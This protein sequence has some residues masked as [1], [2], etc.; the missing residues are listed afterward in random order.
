MSSS[1]D[2]VNEMTDRLKKI[3]SSVGGGGGEDPDEA[4]QANATTEEMEVDLVPQAEPAAPK[5]IAR[6][7]RLLTSAE[8][9]PRPVGVF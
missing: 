3:Q 7:W 4:G 1:D 2:I 5:E 9:T 8:W 6:G